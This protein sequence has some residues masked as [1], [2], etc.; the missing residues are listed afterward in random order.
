MRFLT[1]SKICPATGRNLIEICLEH[2]ITIPNLMKLPPAVYVI[3]DSLLDNSFVCVT[4]LLQSY[5]KVIKE[6]PMKVLKTDQ[7]ANSI[8]EQPF[9][10]TV[11]WRVHAYLE[12]NI[13][14]PETKITENVVDCL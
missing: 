11:V 1:E 7:V 10:K 5:P 3:L 2:T 13:N 14:N 9:W 8:V 4:S 12:V 6:M